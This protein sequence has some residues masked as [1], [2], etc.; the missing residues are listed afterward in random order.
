MT[1]YAIRLDNGVVIHDNEWR[2]VAD[3]MR[4]AHGQ[5]ETAMPGELI[6]IDEEE[7]C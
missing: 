6:I 3:V 7:S 1:R 4:T 2:C 5:G